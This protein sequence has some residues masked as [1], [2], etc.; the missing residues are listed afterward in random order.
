[1]CSRTSKSLSFRRSLGIF[2]CRF[3]L[4][5]LGL[6]SFERNRAH[7]GPDVGVGVLIFFVRD[8]YRG[9]AQVEGKK[10][11]KRQYMS[12]QGRMFCDLLWFLGTCPH[13]DGM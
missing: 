2:C 10:T 12:L 11:P 13:R 6:A 3:G 5:G 4:Y 7:G 1:M 9:Q 8:P